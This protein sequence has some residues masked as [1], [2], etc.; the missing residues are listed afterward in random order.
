MTCVFSCQHSQKGI[1]GNNFFL[2]RSFLKNYIFNWGSPKSSF[3]LL[4]V[5]LD[6][7]RFLKVHMVPCDELQYI[8][9]C[10]AFSLVTSF[11]KRHYVY[12]EDQAREL[13][14][15]FLSFCLQ[16]E[17]GC[18]G[19]SKKV[20]HATSNIMTEGAYFSLAGA[21]LGIMIYGFR[22]LIQLQPYDGFHWVDLKILWVPWKPS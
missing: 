4:R 10:Q 18:W 3:G 8:Q 9:C 7:F 11:V 16:V 5:P 1:F 17:I 14:Y 13:I 19:S 12:M 20:F 6:S 21:A 15:L 22:Y 2:L